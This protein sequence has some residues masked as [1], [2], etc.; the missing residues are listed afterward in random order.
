MLGYVILYSIII[1]PGIVCDVCDVGDDV[2]GG[3]VLLSFFIFTF[4]AFSK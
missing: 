4:F 2:C 1:L 3:R